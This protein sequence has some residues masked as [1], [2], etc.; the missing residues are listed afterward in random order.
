[1]AEKIPEGWVSFPMNPNRRHDVDPVQQARALHA[2]YLAQHAG[3]PM[4][5]AWQDINEARDQRSRDL[6]LYEQA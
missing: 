5:E 1:M 6:D 4:P 2:K 3:K